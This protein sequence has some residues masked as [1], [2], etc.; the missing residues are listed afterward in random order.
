M[1]PRKNQKK[2]KSETVIRTCVSIIKQ[3]WK[4]MGVIPQE[5]DFIT[6]SIKN[7]V[8]KVKQ[9]AKKYYIT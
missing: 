9:L 1:I 6:W 5:S 3:H 2:K 7:F 4:K 8:R